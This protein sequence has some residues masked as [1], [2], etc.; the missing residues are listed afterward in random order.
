MARL[1]I[2]HP[3]RKARKA[4]EGQARNHHQVSV[5]SKV[6]NALKAIEK[7]QP[8]VVVAGLDG[9]RKDGLELLGHLQREKKKVPTILV[10]TAADGKFQ[11]MAMKLGASA[12]LEFP[13]EQAALDHAISEA[14]NAEWADKGKQPPLTEEELNANL[15]ELERELNRRMQCFAGKNQVYLQSFVLGGG[16]TSKP[17]VALKCSLR[18]QFGMPPNVYYEYI[19]DTCCCD[20][21]TCPAYQQ[22]HAKRIG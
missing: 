2:L 18:Q 20:P 5:V 6:S 7:S 10:A 19:R 4:L 22:F 12:F 14:V 8:Q 1:L 3:D 21:S 15:S 17:R 13:V 9:K 11:A 16:Q